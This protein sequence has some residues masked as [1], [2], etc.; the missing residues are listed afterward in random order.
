MND[1]SALG[2]AR[3]IINGMIA[4]TALVLILAQILALSPPQIVW[5]SLFAIYF[6]VNVRELK[7]SGSVILAIAVMAG[8]AA[9]ILNNFR[10][11]SAFE[12]TG[13]FFALL[14]LLQSLARIA[15]RSSDVVQGAQFIV[16]RAPGRRYLFV[17]LGT[18]LLA[19]FLQIGSMVLVMSLLAG[20]F[21]DAGEALTR[22]LALAAMRGFA[23]TAM[24]SPLSMS[25]LVIFSN[26]DGISFLE[27]LPFGLA[28]SALYIMAGYLADRRGPQGTAPPSATS[29][30]QRG[31]LLR[32]LARIL[33]LFAIAVVAIALFDLPLIEGI[34]LAVFTLTIA[35]RLAEWLTKGERRSTVRE[36]SLSA[37]AMVNELAI[38]CGATMIGVIAADLVQNQSG[39]VQALGS[40]EAAAIVS[41][42]P[43]IVFAGGTAAINPLASVT[44]AASILDPIWPPGAKI[45]LAIAL[46]WGWTIT[47]CGT[48]FT[49]NMLVS[50]RLIGRS[51]SAL[52]YGW[53]GRFTAY[54]VLAAGM[55][56]AL[57]VL[58]YS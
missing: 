37:G 24:W 11:H 50:S 49:A 46:S 35:W 55:L 33:F 27:I 8:G 17:S 9:A 29:G 23:C 16:S 30:N 34:F 19:L 39:V 40:G 1:P 48:P 25:I 31:A 20:R 10:P 58:I 53:N 14:V 6:S 45:W 56:A 5:P 4:V 13:F 54:T 51:S 52:A 7:K 36:L 57:G 41:F 28:G 18:H 2:A 21:R 38:I 26:I 12:Q 15:S 43:G 44:I 32:V 42:L 3:T 47:A 22:S